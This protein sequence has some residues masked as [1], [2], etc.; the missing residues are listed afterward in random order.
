MSFRLRWLPQAIHTRRA[1]IDYIAGEDPR[2]AEAQDERIST[3]TQRLA[4]HPHLG[5]TGREVGTRE[6]VVTRTPFVVVYQVDEAARTVSILRVLHGAQQ[7]PAASSQ[8]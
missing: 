1:Q 8:R 6:L 3:A 7:W 5:R 2:A 4:A